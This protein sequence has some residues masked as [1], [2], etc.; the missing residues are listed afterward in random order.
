MRDIGAGGEDDGVTLGLLVVVVEEFSHVENLI[1]NGDPAI[2]VNVVFGDFFRDVV[3]AEFVGT[4]VTF[5]LV[6][7]EVGQFLR[8]WSWNTSSH[9][10]LKINQ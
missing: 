2:I 6:F 8:T 9:F 7:F 5:G 10:N 3:V 4:G 1:E